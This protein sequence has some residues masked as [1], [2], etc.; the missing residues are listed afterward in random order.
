MIMIKH[1]NASDEI[2][3]K[4]ELFFGSE[5]PL[6]FAEKHGGR[7]YE[8]RTQQKTMAI[9]VANSLINSESIC[10]EAPTGVGKSFAYLIPAILFAIEKNIPLAV[11]TETINLQEQIAEKDIPILRKLLNINFSA[12][13]AKGRSNYLCLRR[14]DQSS[15]DHKEEYLP[16]NSLIS[17]L[18]KILKWS[19]TT[20]DGSLS[21]MKFSASNGIWQS[22]CCEEGNCLRNKCPHFKNCFYWKARRSWDEAKI[23]ITNHALFLTDLKVKLNEGDKQGILPI[24][25]AVIIDESHNLEMN[26]AKFMG[27]K[28]GEFS[29]NYT[30]NRLFNPA[31]GRGLLI[32]ESKKAAEVRAIIA[33]TI[34]CSKTFFDSVKTYMDHFSENQKRITNPYC[35]EDVITGQLAYLERELVSLIAEEVNENRKIELDSQRK[36]IGSFAKAI[37]EF[38]TMNAADHVYWIETETKNRH[39]TASLNYS[40]LNVAELLN[41]ALFSKDIPII[42]TSATLAISQSMKFYKNRIG[43]TG[44]EL[45]LDSPFD[46]ANQAKV[47]IS[48]NSPLQESGNYADCISEYVIKYLEKSNGKAFVLFTSYG[49]LAKVKEKT[50]NFFNQNSIKLFAQG[51]GINRSEMLRCF[52]EDINSVI[53]GTT[54]F[55]T[56]VDVPG[57]A[58]SNVIITKLPFGVPSEPLV[59]ARLDKLSQEGRNP[60]MEYSLPDAVLKFKQGVG[61]LI[62]SKTDTGIIVILDG[63]VISK[64]YGKLFLKSLPTCPIIVE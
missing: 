16:L 52:R 59:E 58:L 7:K 43:F 64:H 26:A 61:R 21:D 18:H 17:D 56:G 39:C 48:K 20:L 47:Y 10:I 57:E 35:V 29:L 30:L 28:I 24:F 27:V 55:W 41:K 44:S 37:F 63:R 42:L 54:S 50:K 3:N 1:R 13:I 9:A 49:L 11:T 14:L 15:G 34:E 38:L 2:L 23:I 51:D 4:T 22:V 36:K 62:R 60:F 40:P 32:Y 12:V 25:S 6:A 8:E 31:T 53:Y 45:I 46:Y 19:E 33:K 5:T